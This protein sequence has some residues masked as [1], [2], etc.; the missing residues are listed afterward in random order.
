VRQL[1]ADLQVLGR[2]EFKA[3]LRWR[4]AVSKALSAE[5]SAAGME[6]EVSLLGKR[7]AA[8]GAAATGKAADG[9][10]EGE[11]EGE[12]EE[13]DPEAALLKEMEAARDAAERRDRKEKKKAREMKKKARIRCA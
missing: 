6:G 13:R 10:D 8:A 4:A 11:G 3:L 5:L 7:K 12:G 1:C 2:T 9:D